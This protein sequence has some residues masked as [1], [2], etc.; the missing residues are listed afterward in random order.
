VIPARPERLQK[1]R[2]MSALPGMSSEPA[3]G[4]GAAAIELRSV[5][6]RYGRITAVDGVSLAIGCG[7]IFGLLGPNGAGKTTIIRM[8]TTLARPTAGVLWVAGYD[9][10][11]SPVEVKRRIGVVPQQN[12]LERELTGRENL[13]LHALLHKM[14]RAER[15]RRINELLDYM[16]LA[17]RAD[18]RVQHYSGGWRAVS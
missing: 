15:E 9:V 16:G 10:A 6:K 11:T 4:G 7:E 8:L 3:P 1:N 18:E 14:G 12:N 5:V 2:G 17:S 13:L